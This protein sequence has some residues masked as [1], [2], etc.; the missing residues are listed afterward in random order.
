MD[1]KT[2]YCQLN[3]KAWN[4][5]IPQHKK[6]MDEKWDTM[7]SDPH[8]IFQKGVELEELRKIGIK[9]KR[10]A[11]FSCNNGIELMS[12]KRMGASRCVGFDICDAAVDEALMR[13][14]KFNI[15][16]EF[17]RTNVLD[18]PENY[19]NSFDLVYVTVGALVWIP[20]LTAYI[21]KAADLLVKGGY[22]FIYEHHPYASIFTFDEEKDPL[23]VVDHYFKEGVEEW[24]DG[25]DYYAGSEYK[26]PPTYEFPYTISKLLNAV[27]SNNMNLKVFNEFENDIAICF[28]RLEE[29]EI[30]LPLSYI[31][32]AI[33]LKEL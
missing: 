14:G 13:S 3:R 24:T 32:I 18:I 25:L 23:T 27:A 2:D 16:C 33:K 17:I 15:E 29:A 5:A 21:K 19:N 26:S 22:L 28:K 20:D 31:L 10:I 9:G 11:H 30:R 1:K 8:F 12:L 4:A 6:A 7:Y